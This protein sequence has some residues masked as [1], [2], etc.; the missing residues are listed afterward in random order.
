M[1]AY[2]VGFAVGILLGLILVAIIFA[3]KK[4]KRGK[5]EY[6]ERQ[7]LIRC[8]GYKIA[9]FTLM[10]CTAFVLCF[11]AGDGFKYVDTDTAFVISI[12]I[13]I[14]V[15]AIYC[16]IKD[17]YFGVFEKP[18]SVLV[19]L[20]IIGVANLVIG[21]VNK[22]KWFVDGKLSMGSTNIICAVTI[23]IVTLAGMI[24]LLLV[25]REDE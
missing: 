3:V 14:V 1:S 19:E 2:N 24:K 15:F 20:F 21:L 17:G 6:D 5:G 16:I 22:E 8:R 13:S 12:M 7:E 25:K 18:K 23:L 4:K 9:Y 10:I 11:K